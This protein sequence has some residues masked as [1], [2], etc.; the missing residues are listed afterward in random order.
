MWLEFLLVLVS[1]FLAFYRYVTKN[2][3]KWKSLGIPHTSGHFPFGS[4]NFLSGRH[5]DE[6][7]AEDHLKFS[8]E[9]YFGWFLFGKPILALNDANLLRHVMVKDFDHFVD[10]QPHEQVRKQFSGGDLDKVSIN[11]YFMK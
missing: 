8:S 7:S 11:K 9:K 4:Y 1:L 6:V 10:R 5:M 3:G 2:F